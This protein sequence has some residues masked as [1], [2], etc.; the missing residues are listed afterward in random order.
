MLYPASYVFMA[1]DRG[2]SLLNSWASTHIS[3][4]SYRKYDDKLFNNTVTLYSVSYVLMAAEGG[5]SPRNS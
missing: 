2:W 3:N 1:F 5:W 4:T